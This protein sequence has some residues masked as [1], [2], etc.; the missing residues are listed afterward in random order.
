MLFFGNSFQF[1]DFILKN[2]FHFDD[3]LI[4]F[5]FDLTGFFLKIPFN[6]MIFFLKNS[7][8]LTI[9]FLNSK[10]QTDEKNCESLFFP[11]FLRILSLKLVKH[12]L[13]TL[14]GVGAVALPDGRVLICGGSYTELASGGR[15]RRNFGAKIQSFFFKHLRELYVTKKPLNFRG[16]IQMYFWSFLAQK[17]KN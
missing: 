5:I 6:L 9:F 16:K 15:V 11:F 7:F 12:N 2:S 10:S 8:Q 1:D 14:G 17:Y 13:L 4:F 3:F